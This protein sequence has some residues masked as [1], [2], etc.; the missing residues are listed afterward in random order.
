MDDRNDS[1][2]YQPDKSI[3]DSD[4]NSDLESLDD[5][6]VKSITS[7]QS[8]LQR[9]KTKLKNKFGK[10]NDALDL[11]FSDSRSSKVSDTTSIFEADPY[12]YNKSKLVKKYGHLKDQ[13]TIQ[14]LFFNMS[15]N[16]NTTTKAEN[17]NSDH[18]V[19]IIKIS[20][21]RNYLAAGKQNGLIYIYERERDDVID[22]EQTENTVKPEKVQH[23]AASM[24]VK[25]ADGQD[26]SS[27]RNKTSVTSDTASISGSYKPNNVFKPTPLKILAHHKFAITDLAWGDGQFLLSSSLDTHVCLWHISLDECLSVFKHTDSVICVKFVPNSLEIVLHF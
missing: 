4:A 21:D 27:V 9:I 14:N 17:E 10:K 26:N 24:K 25:P 1:I 20:K 15:L 11:K 13:N 7:P 2:S 5:K 3:F 8:K 23:D 6:E 22:G 12:R 16:T 18:A 19:W